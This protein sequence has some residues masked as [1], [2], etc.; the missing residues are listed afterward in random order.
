MSNVE[1]AWSKYDSEMDISPEPEGPPAIRNAGKAVF[2]YQRDIS[3]P[4]P[5]K[6]RARNGEKLRRIVL[7]DVDAATVRLIFDNYLAGMRVS[8]IKEL[9]DETRKISPSARRAADQSGTVTF[10]PWR[11]E[12]VSDML[13]NP[14]YTGFRVRKADD[15]SGR[16]ERSRVR[17]HD[18]IVTV[19][20]FMSAR[21]LI[22]SDRRVQRTRKHPTL[23]LQGMVECGLCGSTMAKYGQSY[24]CQAKPSGTAVPKAHERNVVVRESVLLPLAIEWLL[25]VTDPDSC[26][27]S[28]KNLTTP[29]AQEAVRIT[30]RDVRRVRKMSDWD[31]VW[32]RHVLACAPYIK[33]R[34][35]LEAVRDGSAEFNP[36]NG[37]L[38]ALNA[39]FKTVGLRV[40]CDGQKVVMRLSTVV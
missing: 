23:A 16:I 25:A 39:L 26:K 9:L 33:A 11:A 6:T 24:R 32:A 7:H 2:G 38:P 37:D 40:I 12:S 28:A 20:E 10:Q 18:R 31:P 15:G 34:G 13:A 29:A 3:K 27:E 1:S 8:A 22:R 19:S 36:V 21:E 5:D 4:H 30:S 35:L 17:T 14:G